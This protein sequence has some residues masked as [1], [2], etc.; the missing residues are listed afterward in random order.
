MNVSKRRKEQ[1]VQPRSMQKEHLKN[2][3]IA[4]EKK[5]PKK[6]HQSVVQ[7]NSPD[8]RH[9]VWKLKNSVERLKKRDLH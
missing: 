7:K 9:L 1:Y 8:Q 2:M 4:T 6:R 3:V 5:E